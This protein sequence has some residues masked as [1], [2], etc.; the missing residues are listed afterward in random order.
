MDSGDAENARRDTIDDIIPRIE[1]ALDERFY[2]DNY[3]Y[4]D[5]P[6]SESVVHQVMEIIREEL[7]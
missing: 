2:I 3:S 4:H 1:K 6:S 7:K 5:A